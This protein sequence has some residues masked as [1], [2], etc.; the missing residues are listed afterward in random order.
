VFYIIIHFSVD[1]SLFLLP[2]S[3]TIF[4][5]LSHAKMKLKFSA[6]IGIYLVLG[7]GKSSQLPPAILTYKTTSFARRK[8]TC[9]A[10]PVRR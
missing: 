10:R 9:C 2:N 5:A 7:T 8:G 6:L 4:L 3:K 1:L